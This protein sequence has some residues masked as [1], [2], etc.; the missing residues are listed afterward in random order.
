MWKYLFRVKRADDPRC[1]LNLDLTLQCG[2]NFRWRRR[3]DG[4]WT[5]PV[6]SRLF[7]LRQ[8]RDGV[9]FRILHDDQPSGV[10]GLQDLQ[11][12]FRMSHDLKELYARWGRV[13]DGAA[14]AVKSGLDVRECFAEASQALPGLRLIDQDPVECIFSFICS[15]NNHISR[16]SSMVERLASFGR[17][18]HDDADGMRWHEFPTLETI[19]DVG[20]ERLR[21]MGFG[22]RA[23]FIGPAASAI[24]NSGGENWLKELRKNRCTRDVLAELR[25]LPGVGQKVASCVALFSLNKLEC[26]PVDVHVYNIVKRCCPD[27]FEESKTLTLKLHEKVQTY[28]TTN[29]GDAAG[30]AHCVLFAAE[31]PQFK[32][33]ERS[34]K[35]RKRSS[36]T[37]TS[38]TAVPQK[39]KM[40][41]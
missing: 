24:L 22:Y 33:V 26:V 32:V 19:A 18:L 20:E 21:T 38:T 1:V 30:W 10:S 41:K 34:P 23:K 36:T 2:Q 25:A 8:V 16:I 29:W 13:G 11:R 7:S 15:Q 4:V 5:G 6:R 3:A 27:E 9:Q 35:K 40:K 28:F 17:V 14:A 39:K 12:Y 37:K 31:L